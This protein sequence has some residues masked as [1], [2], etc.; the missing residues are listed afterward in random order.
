VF[1]EFA[2]VAL[3]LTLMLAVSVEFGRVT[4]SAQAIQDAARLAARELAVTPLP[5]AITFEDA[6]AFTD[7]DPMSPTFGVAIVKERI[8]D[9]ACLVVDLDTIADDAA[10]DAL[11]ASMPLVNKALRAVMILDQQGGRNLLRYPGAVL[12]DA[13]DPPPTCKAQPPTG[14]T[15]GIPRVVSRGESG[16]ETI[17]W[18]GVLEE[19]RASADPTTGPFGLVAV[20]PQTSGVVAV[21]INYPFQAAMLSGFRA[22][23]PTVADPLPPNVANI[24]EANDAGVAATN[25]A[26]GGP[27]GGAAEIGPY[28]GAYGLG[29]QLAFI[30]NV[31][32]FRKLLSAQAIYR[33]EVFQ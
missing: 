16:V 26:P 28:A 10:L 12:T 5:A 30:K 27:V 24:I 18:I 4:F 7:D 2:L 25:P 3:V 23:P 19:I 8:F 22:T 31:R 6:L 17:E 13:T 15:V 21:R 20:A 32:P 9:P 14:L 29:R 33:R 1:V 11:F